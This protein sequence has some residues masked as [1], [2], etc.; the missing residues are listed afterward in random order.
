[1]LHLFPLLWGLGFIT[2]PVA[3][4][5]KALFTD[6]KCN[7]CHTIESQGIAVLPKANADEEEDEGSEPNDLSQVGSDHDVAQI[8]QWLQRTLEKDGKKH[9]K[10][11]VGSDEELDAIAQWLVSLK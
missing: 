4:D 1:M 6:K 8:K 5:G 11:F 10:K 3:V 2:H 9:K 7:K